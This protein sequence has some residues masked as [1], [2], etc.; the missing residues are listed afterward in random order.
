MG[1]LQEF[2]DTGHPT[3][4]V[5]SRIKGRRTHLIS[6]WAH[7]LYSPHPLDDLRA[8]PYRDFLDESS[9]EGIWRWLTEE[10]QWVYRTVNREVQS[11]FSP[12]FLYYEI[13]RTLLPGF[14]YRVRMD[15]AEGFERMLSTSL[16]SKKMKKALKK[17]TP[18]DIL[19][20]IEE[21]FHLLSDTFSGLKQWFFTNGLMTFEQRF[22]A[23][24]LEYTVQSD[25]HPVLE[26]FFRYIIDVRNSITLYKHL[27]WGIA[28]SPLFVSGGRLSEKKL[29]AVFHKQDISGLDICIVKLTGLKTEDIDLAVIEVLLLSRLLKDIQR[30]GRDP[31]GL[32]QILDYLWRCYIQA[33]NLGIILFGREIE[34]EMVARELIQ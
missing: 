12:F 4:Y 13:E 16:L 11:V 18:A 24:Y 6:D 19:S 1:R 14:R 17:E 9:P 23:V 34:K 21:Q 3:D 32:E 28:T 22:M 10:F 29:N 2:V 26:R 5:L 27:R 15:T 7:L 33:L 30:S 25:L 8:T 20:G 31:L